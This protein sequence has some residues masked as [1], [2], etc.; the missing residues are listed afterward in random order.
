M[1]DRPAA[2][3]IRLEQ[4]L[5]GGERVGVSS[6]AVFELWH[7][8]AKSGKIAFNTERLSTF[9]SRLPTLP[10]D[11]EDARIAGQIRADLSRIGRPIGSYDL[12]IAGHAL[13]HDL[14]LITANVR[15]FSRVQGL[16]WED[17][18]QPA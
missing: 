13:R 5:E 16:R 12:L 1:N 14:V 17:W 2:V 11:E 6:I 7:G 18:T 15:E 3:R 4:A 10:F 8:V 9:L